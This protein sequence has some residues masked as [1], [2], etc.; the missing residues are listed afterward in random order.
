VKILC[1]VKEDYK[2]RELNVIDR[3]DLKEGVLIWEIWI[4][5]A[6]TVVQDFGCVKRIK[7]AAYLS[8]SLLCGKV[9]LPPV[10]DPPP[11]LLDLYT[12]SHSDAISFRKNI[13]AYN[14]ILAC[15]SFGA[16]IDES[17]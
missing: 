10:F 11:Y 3:G 8:L 6:C 5:H 12:L 14:G 13:R 7:L 2:K 1:H 15:S 16:K 9:C 4:R 17:F